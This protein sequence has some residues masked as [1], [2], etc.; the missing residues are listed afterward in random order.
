MPQ[1]LCQPAVQEGIAAARESVEQYLL[2][3]FEEIARLQEAEEF[4]QNVDEIQARTDD[5]ATWQVQREQL[6]AVE[7]CAKSCTCEEGALLVVKEYNTLAQE[8]PETAALVPV[9]L[10][11][12]AGVPLSIAGI[13]VAVILAG[14]LI[15]WRLRSV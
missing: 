6:S 9:P 15:A 11:Q 13:V 4:L 14:I 3:T 2:N 7:E 1:E 5:V 8:Q 12:P 10:P